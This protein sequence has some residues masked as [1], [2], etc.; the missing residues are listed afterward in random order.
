[1]VQSVFRSVSAIVIALAVAVF[2][3]M[4]TEGIGSWLYPLPEDF[5]GTFEEIAQQVATTPAL[6]LVLLGGL[7]YGLTML[8]ATFIATRLGYQRKAWHG[9]VVGAVL[10]GMVIMNMTMLPYPTWFWVQELLVLSVAA[11]FG[12]RLGA[13]Q[14][15]DA[16]T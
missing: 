11:F 8:A 6:N 7:C 1:M 15:A 10:L 13:G 12:T 14:Q 9:Y 3:F 2:L 4:V 16:A 5:G